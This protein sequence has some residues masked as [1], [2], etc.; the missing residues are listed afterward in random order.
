[1]DML[2]PVILSLIE[3][4]LSSEVKISCKI[5]KVGFFGIREV[6]SVFLQYCTFSVCMYVL[7]LRACI[8]CPDGRHNTQYIMYN[9]KSR[10]FRWLFKDKIVFS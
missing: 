1:M 9:T 4:V 5:H 6:K 2:G 8:A 3:V 10:F 7:Y